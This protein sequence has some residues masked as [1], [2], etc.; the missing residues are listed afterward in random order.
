MAEV[1]REEEEEEGVVE[2]ALE[3]RRDASGNIRKKTV[4]KRFLTTIL[5]TINRIHNIA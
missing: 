5:M 4:S 2:E 3:P 1:K